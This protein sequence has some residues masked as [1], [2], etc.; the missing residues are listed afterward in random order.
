MSRWLR[1][2]RREDDE[3]LYEAAIVADELV[4]E[5]DLPLDYTIY[6]VHTKW[7]R[8][9]KRVSPE[10]PIP[11]RPLRSDTLQNVAQ[12]VR[13]IKKEYRDYGYSAQVVGPDGVASG[14]TRLRRSAA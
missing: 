9:G 2:W 8:F 14:R 6:F 4:E 10:K 3:E 12:L 1:A 11:Y 7:W 13:A 5:S